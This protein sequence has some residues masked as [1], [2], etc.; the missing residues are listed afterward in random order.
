MRQRKLTC[1]MRVR[2]SSAA[3]CHWQD[4]LVERARYLDE[5]LAAHMGV[6]YMFEFPDEMRY[7]GK[8]VNFEIRMRA[9]E[10][11]EQSCPKLQQWKKKWGW[12]SIKV[13]KLL[14][15]VPNEQLNAEEVNAI[16]EYNTQWPNGLNMTIGGDGDSESTRLSWQDAN[17]RNKRVDGLR[18]AWKDT[19][20]RDRLMVGAQ[21]RA[22]HARK[23]CATPEANA[24]RST[25]WEEKREA[26]LALL[27]PAEAEVLRETMRKDRAK[28]LAYKERKRQRAR[29]HADAVHL[30]ALGVL[31]DGAVSKEGQSEQVDMY[32]SSINADVPDE[33]V[34]GGDK[35]EAPG[36]NLV[37]T[38]CESGEESD[39][40]F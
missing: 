6:I 40:W 23:T 19:E 2:G 21:E 16:A 25:K 4:R 28:A 5:A 17:V 30:E 13:S 20:K 18:A 34:V 14:D 37:D 22:E 3:G 8:T 10:R 9:H 35:A 39:D 31:A 24:K 38:L 33:G 12:S 11:Y 32:E 26:R 36:G 1:G 7:I 27:P 29:H 15:E